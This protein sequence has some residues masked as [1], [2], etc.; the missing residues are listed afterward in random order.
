MFANRES[1]RV[2]AG[3][4]HRIAAD[5]ALET[6]STAEVFDG[7][8]V[9]VFALPGAFTPTCSSAHVPRYEELAP[10]FAAA[11]VDAIVCVSVND[12]FVMHAWGEDQGAETVQM[13][14]DGNGDWTKA[15][16]LLVDKSAIG[17]GPRS[18][19]YSMLVRDGVVEK[20]FIE[21]DVPGDPYEV[22]DADTMLGHL[23]PERATHTP[24]IVLF[25]KQ[26]CGHCRR[27]KAQL[28]EAGLAYEDVPA[29]PRMLRALSSTPTTPRVFVDGALIGGA[30]AL[31]AWLAAR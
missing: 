28:A 6:V 2:P 5:G 9:I 26:G 18:W 3:Q 15:M 29:T 31:E 20:Q 17:F 19:R 12:A 4:F 27:A 1:Q 8:T 14:A 22:S 24:D 21:P 30:D 7:K 23:A 13:L 11:G 10:Q 25:T 16:G